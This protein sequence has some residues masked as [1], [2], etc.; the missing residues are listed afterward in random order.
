MRHLLTIFALVVTVLAMPIQVLA[1]GHY[2]VDSKVSTVSFA[3][4]K[5][6]YIVEPAVITG[7]TGSLDDSG[8]LK[9]MVPLQNLDT[10]V[11][12]RNDRL[13]ELFFKVA[14][15]PNVEVM[16][17]VPA[18]LMKGDM[19]VTQAKVPAQVTLYGKAQT[20]DFML[21][22][23]RAGN[24]ISVSSVKPV[25]IDGISFGIPK[26]SLAAV[27]KTVGDIAISSSVGVNVSLVLKK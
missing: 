16:A 22:I 5:K 4:I 6:Q 27:S 10:G 9:V 14:T 11:S 24:V 13:G 8:N 23:V 26:E 3:T 2:E 15:H 21:N 18:E 17:T 25:V 12:I 7:L 1:A 20:L 19:V